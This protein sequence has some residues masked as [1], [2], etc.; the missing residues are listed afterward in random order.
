[1][2]GIEKKLM[3]EQNLAKD[4]DY[5]TDSTTV[6]DTRITAETHATDSYQN[7]LFSLIRFRLHIGVYPERVTVVTHEFKRERFMECHFPALGLDNASRLRLIGINPPEEVTPGKEL[8]EGEGKRGIGLWRVDMYGVGKELA[9]KRAKRG[10]VRG[11]ERDAFFGMELEPVVEQ[12][13]CWD[14]GNRGN[15]RFPKL[16][17]LPWY[18]RS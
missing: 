10:W 4:N 13:A 15:S 6:D 3:E 16:S 7:V 9:G 12:L 18:R 8:V 5:F 11:M 17:E 14:G 1:M 2:N